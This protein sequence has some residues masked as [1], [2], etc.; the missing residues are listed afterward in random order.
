MAPVS[1]DKC[2]RRC[3][4]PIFSAR[5]KHADCG[6]H[7]SALNSRLICSATGGCQGAITPVPHELCVETEQEACLFHIDHTYF[8]LLG[9]IASGSMQHED[10]SCFATDS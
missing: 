1:R 5:G 8:V 3:T 9:N 2:G 10:V 4:S 6:Q 7:G